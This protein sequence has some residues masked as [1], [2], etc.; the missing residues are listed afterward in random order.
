MNASP[1]GCPCTKLNRQN[2]LEFLCLFGAFAPFIEQPL[3]TMV[4]R[5]GV[6]NAVHIPE[7][8]IPY[9]HPGRL[10]CS[11]NRPKNVKYVELLLCTADRVI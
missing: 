11:Q 4:Y 5:W 2:V 1:L 7:R 8:Y 6:S 10:Y 9:A 3:I